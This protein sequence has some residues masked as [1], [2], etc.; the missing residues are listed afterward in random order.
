MSIVTF[1]YGQNQTI[2]TQGYG[3][4]VLFMYSGRWV[5]ADQMTGDP[6]HDW[7]LTVSDKHYGSPARIAIRFLNYDTEA[8][9][10]ISD[11]DI[12]VGEPIDTLKEIYKNY[13]VSA[14][15]VAFCEKTVEAYSEL[16]NGNDQGFIDKLKELESV[17]NSMLSE[18]TK[19]NHKVMFEITGIP[20]ERAYI[21]TLK[22]I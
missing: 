15:F 18:M 13:A 7:K 4:S 1:G 14:I 10:Y 9:N 17:V 12:L 21:T 5:V 19:H 3:A 22:I 16:D 8:L 20:A 11:D 6:Y 2:I